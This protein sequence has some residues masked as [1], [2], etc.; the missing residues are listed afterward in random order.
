MDEILQRKIGQSLEVIEMFVEGKKDE[1][2]EL[3]MTTFVMCDDQTGGEV[4]TET[5]YEIENTS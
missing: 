5:T 3:R 4:L 1:K 2:M